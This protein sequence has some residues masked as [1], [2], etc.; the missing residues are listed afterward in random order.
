MIK[1]NKSNSIILNYDEKASDLF[2]W[3]QQLVAESLGKKS[4]G[5][6]PII[7]KMP[8]D[9]HSLMQFYLDGKQN[10]FYSFFFTQ[11]IISQNLNKKKLLKSHNYLKGKN[12]KDISYNQ[13]FAT[14]SV[15]KKKNIPF[16]T[17]LIEKRDEK[18]LGT[19][20]T[21]FILETILLGKA[22]N[23]NPYDQPSV[24]LIKKETKKRLLKN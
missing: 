21:Y 7:S 18:S 2:Y 3:Y 24:E 22:L 14:Q 6:L 13:Y 8:Q 17:F 11:E 4:K 23:I 5:I 10:N 19:L 16:R 20:F 12:L 9:N 15:F 1:K